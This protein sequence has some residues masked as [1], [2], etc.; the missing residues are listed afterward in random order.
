MTV[1]TICVCMVINR[2]P[3]SN[4]AP[5]WMGPY[6]RS[7]STRVWTCIS[8]K[9]MISYDFMI[10][11]TWL[12]VGQT[13]TVQAIFRKLYILRSHK[14]KSYYSTTTSIPFRR[15]GC[16]LEFPIDLRLL[17]SGG[18]LN[19]TPSAWSKGVNKLGTSSSVPSFHAI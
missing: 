17:V 5:G 19:P 13:S 1:C 18:T 11:V 9:R 8:E 7:N 16:P 3:P 6:S 2:G 4:R 15:L 14:V 10:G 12:F